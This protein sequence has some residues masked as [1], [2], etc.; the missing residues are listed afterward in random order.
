M[1]IVSEIRAWKAD[2]ANELTG[3]RIVSQRV[4]F[5]ASVV[6][7]PERFNP[8]PTRLP[9]LLSVPVHP[10]SVSSWR[11]LPLLVFKIDISLKRFASIG[12]TLRQIL[13]K[14]SQLPHSPASSFATDPPPRRSLWQSIPVSHRKRMSG[15]R[16]LH[17]RR[18][19]YQLGRSR[20]L[21]HWGG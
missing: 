9:Y 21:L 20:L 1:D 4:D 13:R 2:R 15:G 7:N 6:V 14:Q 3:S 12:P 5:R 17:S 16:C 10:R 8:A 11:R 19:R 18:R